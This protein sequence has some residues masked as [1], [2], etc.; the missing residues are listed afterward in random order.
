MRTS[1]RPSAAHS[2]AIDSTADIVIA[3]VGQQR[4]VGKAVRIDMC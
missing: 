1:R 4:I 3:L 2:S